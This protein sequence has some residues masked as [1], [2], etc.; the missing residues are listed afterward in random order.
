MIPMVI[1]DLSGK[2]RRRGSEPAQH[3]LSVR[4][5]TLWRLNKRCLRG[6]EDRPKRR[7]TAALQRATCSERGYCLRP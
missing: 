5:R 6:K 2:L 3:C 4:K 7:R 1:D